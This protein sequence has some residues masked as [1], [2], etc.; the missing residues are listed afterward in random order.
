V[1]WSAKR[2]R[3]N[4]LAVFE[5]SQASIVDL[6]KRHSFPNLTAG[7]LPLRAIL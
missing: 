3:K 6:R 1:L 5:S 7:I 4:Q 2:F